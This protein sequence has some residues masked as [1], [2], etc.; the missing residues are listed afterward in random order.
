MG[1]DKKTPTG[2]NILI[3]EDEPINYMILEKI[4]STM[5]ANIFWAKDGIEAVDMA[6]SHHDIQ[7]V[8]MDIR[9]PEMDGFEAT[10]II[11]SEF[12]ELAIIMLTAYTLSNEEELCIKAGATAFLT[13][14][15]RPVELRQVINEIAIK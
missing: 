2:L 12:P 10:K 13:K 14:P 3:A 1:T 9:M 7:M 6:R 5:G 11:R 4:L 8:F 15:I